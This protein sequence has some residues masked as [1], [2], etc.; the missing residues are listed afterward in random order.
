MGFFNKNKKNNNDKDNTK[1]SQ[2]SKQSESLGQKLRKIFGGKSLSEEDIEKIEE[3]L[4]TA[5]IGP[6]ISYE[7]I[8]K[9]RKKNITNIEDGIAL[10][11]EEMEKYLI[12]KFSNIERGELNIILVLGVNGVGKTT[13]IAKIANHYLKRRF[14]VLIAAADTFRA[15]ATEQ[16]TKWANKLDVPIIKQGEG[17]DPA[18]IVYDA[19]ESAISKGVDLLLIDTAGRLHTKS[20]LMD[21]LKKIEKIIKN[22][23]NFIKNNLLVIDGTTGQNAYLQAESFNSL[24]GVDGIMITKYDAQSKGGIVFTIQKKLGIPFFFI[25]NGEQIDDIEEFRRHDFIEK[26]F[27]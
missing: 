22:K 13:S 10:I 23:G 14:K 12:E 3:I 15:A 11:K 26:I 25:G 16:L 2:N 17:A 20:N 9:L 24:I 4:I 18:S 1:I 21:E 27:S 6:A 7:L 19:I 5:D 8:E